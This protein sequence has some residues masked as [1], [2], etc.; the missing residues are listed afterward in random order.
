MAWLCPIFRA[1]SRPATT[2]DEALTHA[3]EAILLHLEGVMDEKKPAPVS[4]QHI[5]KRWLPGTDSNR[6]PSD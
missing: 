4:I 2:L 1:A 5:E 6:R 3:K